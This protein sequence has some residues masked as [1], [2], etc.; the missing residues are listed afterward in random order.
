MPAQES[1]TFYMNFI[2]ELREQYVPELIKGN[3]MD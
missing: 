2:T 3:I 1:E